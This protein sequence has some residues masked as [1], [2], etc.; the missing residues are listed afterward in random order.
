MSTAQAI[1]IRALV[2]A[3]VLAS[4]ETPATDQLTVSLETLN[5][6][7]EA[8]RDEGIDFGLSELQLMSTVNIDSGA[9]RALIYNLAIEL[10]NDQQ[11]SVP[12]KTADIAERSRMSL[13]A[14]FMGAQRVRFD[15]ALTRRGR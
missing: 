4:G 12:D 15:S 10:G 14:R 5:D 13:A 9:M 2:K 8:W 11:V 6:L 7:L 3:H 1:I